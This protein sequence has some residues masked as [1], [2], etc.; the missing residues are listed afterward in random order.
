MK[1]ER[2]IASIKGKSKNLRVQKRSYCSYKK[3]NC[4]K[5]GTLVGLDGKVVAYTAPSASISPDNGD[6]NLTLDQLM[7]EMNLECHPV[8]GQLSDWGLCFI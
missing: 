3:G 5:I 2:S 7:L 8:F 6:G 4:W 1:E